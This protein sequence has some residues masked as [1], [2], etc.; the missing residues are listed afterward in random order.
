[1]EQRPASEE[2]VDAWVEDQLQR[3][4][5]QQL[6]V[7][8]DIQDD[9]HAWANLPQPIARSA[10]QGPSYES[11]TSTPREPLVEPPD[12]PEEI[13]FWR[14]LLLLPLAM[15][16][17]R[18]S[19]RTSEPL[20][21]LAFIL[22]AVAIVASAF[23]PLIRNYGRDHNPP[24]PQT[25]ANS[26]PQAVPHSEVPWDERPLNAAAEAILKKEYP[27]KKKRAAARRK[28]WHVVARRSHRGEQS[29]PIS[30]TEPNPLTD[31]AQGAAEPQQPSTIEARLSHLSSLYNNGVIDDVEYQDKRQ[32]IIDE[33]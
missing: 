17:A 19:T 23:A 25:T 21:L 1:M 7:H 3:R 14:L 27:S 20:V 10:K 24:A 15:Y 33:I 8:T 5:S 30:T 16:A 28:T 4:H 22:G 6:I 18:A 26:A 11:I 12:P 13:A 31:E 9:L 2:Y 29:Q 32:A